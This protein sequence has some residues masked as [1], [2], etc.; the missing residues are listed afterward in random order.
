MDELK[1]RIKELNRLAEELSEKCK[2]MQAAVDA[3]SAAA[4]VGHGDIGQLIFRA[5]ETTKAYEHTRASVLDL[6]RGSQKLLRSKA[7][8]GRKRGVNFP[9]HPSERS[10]PK[11]PE[12]YSAQQ[13]LETL[14]LVSTGMQALIVSVEAFEAL[15]VQI[16]TALEELRA[17]MARLEQF[18]ASTDD[19]LKTL[20]NLEA[21]FEDGEEPRDQL[22][23]SIKDL[24]RTWN[25]RAENALEQR[26]CETRTEL[27]TLV[28]RLD[29]LKA[30]SDADIVL[31]TS[32]KSRCDQK[33]SHEQ[34]LH[35]LQEVLH[36]FQERSQETSKELHAH[37]EKLVAEARE[38]LAETHP[39]MP[40]AVALR[41]LLE[42]LTAL[43]EHELVPYLDE[44]EKKVAEAHHA[45]LNALKR[46]ELQIAEDNEYIFSKST[47]LEQIGVAMLAVAE[48][49]E[50]YSGP[51]W[52]VGEDVILRVM[53]AGFD[54]KDFY[55]RFGYSIIA[56]ALHAALDRNELPQALSFL[57]TGFLPPV[58]DSPDER[59]RTLLH[60]SRIRNVFREAARRD[61]LRL[62]PEAFYALS[63]K[64]HETLLTLLNYADDLALSVKDRLQWAAL[65]HNAFA[66]GSEKHHQVS[67]LFLLTL[68]HAK[69]YLG[70]YYSLKAL[71]LHYPD[72]WKEP[73]FRPM[74]R[75]LV[76]QA[77]DLGADGKRFLID[78]CLS[79]DTARLAEN[80]FETEFLLAS[81]AHYSAMRW[82]HTGLLNAAWATWGQLIEQYPTLADVLCRQLSGERFLS[83]TDAAEL[84]REYDGL[85]ESI[86][87]RL[88]APGYQGVALA[89]SIHRWYVSEYMQDWFQ[90]LQ[91]K[92]LS[93]K[94]V[95]ELSTSVTQFHQVEDLVEACPLQNDPPNPVWR[96]IEGRLK[97]KLNGRLTELLELF[98]QS[99]RIR[100]QLLSQSNGQEI[101]TGD[102]SKELNHIRKLSETTDWAVEQLLKPWLS[103]IS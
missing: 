59:I 89:A 99:I 66:L 90:Q 87:S 83:K 97:D 95:E 62:K 36:T 8:T 51:L 65:L 78:L 91:A 53:L 18:G 55:D 46:Y 58:G 94:Q 72:L 54:A 84:K 32:L 52:T 43:D 35:D 39:E 56:S 28:T 45:C 98:R 21:R 71:A 1:A 6:V 48:Q 19:D 44:L 20:E 69:Q 25:Q 82:E 12:D 23:R 80:D 68:L 42:M 63:A 2:Q 61:L 33:E 11:K 34:L 101:S 37:Q 4:Q 81:L 13:L 64:H 49:P 100:Q 38:L 7:N 93:A 96:P 103:F 67:Y 79:P 85:M 92:R 5:S 3:L 77:L 70:L 86:A 75:H 29:A 26:I 74:L 17:E 14:G 15:Q 50:Q 10:L 102:L 24:T 30:V 9:D 57:N 40:E 60:E 88:K 31:L 41:N 16:S 22:L 73:G 47:E 76:V 27:E